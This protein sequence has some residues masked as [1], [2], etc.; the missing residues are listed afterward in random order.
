MNFRADLAGLAQPGLLR[1]FVRFLGGKRGL[2]RAGIPD[3][4]KTCANRDP[5]IGQLCL[6]KGWL[7]SPKIHRLLTLQSDRELR[8]GDAAVEAGWLTT[9]QVEELLKLQS[10]SFLLFLDTLLD[11]RILEE[12]QIDVLLEEYGEELRRHPEA[13]A[14]ESPPRRSVRPLTG[15]EIR[16]GLRKVRSLGALPAVVLR[17]LALTHDP[18]CNPGELTELLS[19]DPNLSAQLLRIVNSAFVASS[20]TISSLHQAVLRIGSAGVRVVALTAAALEQFRSGG[21]KDRG[22]KIWRHS[23]LCSQWS[24]VLA[25]QAGLRPFED[26][27][28]AGLVHDIGRVVIEREFPAAAGEIERLTFQGRT[29]EEAE[30]ERLGQTHADI[31]AYLADL[32]KFPPAIVEA[33]ARH[34]A[35]HVELQASKGSPALVPIVNSACFLSGLPFQPYEEGQNRMLIE[36]LPP[37]LRAQHGLDERLLRFVPRIYEKAGEQASWLG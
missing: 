7:D 36:G 16:A 24:R 18:D 19:A 27:F 5:R 11:F 13:A 30:R 15:D 21:D 37:E 9:G 31:G 26:A 6:R 34:H 33:I 1:P 10:N 14:P 29:L 28:V 32:W 4:L 8:F 22:R 20:R 23:V 2:N 25:E 3:L 12:D 35:P 17:V